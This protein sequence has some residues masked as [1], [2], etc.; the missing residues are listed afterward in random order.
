MRNVCDETHQVFIDEH[1]QL[2][3]GGV[4]DLMLPMNLKAPKN[5]G[6]EP[7]DRLREKITPYDLKT[8]WIW[9]KNSICRNLPATT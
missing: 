2:R 1:C 9:E 3:E 5:T 7:C 8:A 6:K 4:A